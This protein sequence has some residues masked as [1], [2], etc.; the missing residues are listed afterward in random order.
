MR[1]HN[2]ARNPSRR[3]YR[4]RASQRLKRTIFE[5]R[6]FPRLQK[7]TGSFNKLLHQKTFTHTLGD[8]F[9]GFSR[10][11]FGFTFRLI[12]RNRRTLRNDRGTWRWR[13]MRFLVHGLQPIGK[14]L[15]NRRPGVFV[16]NLPLVH[17]VVVDQHAQ[18]LAVHHHFFERADF[19]LRIHAGFETIHEI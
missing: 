18:Q 9:H 4:V 7:T 10:R 5:G 13:R 17:T 2:R 14:I 15:A 12:G 16:E 19:F 1:F 3:E 6:S 11:R 8:R